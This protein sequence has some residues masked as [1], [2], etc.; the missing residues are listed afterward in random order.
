MGKHTAGPWGVGTMTET[1][2][3]GI[4]VEDGP[5]VA[6][7]TKWTSVATSDP[8]VI[9]ANASLIAAAPELLEALEAIMSSVDAKKVRLDVYELELAERAIAKANGDEPPPNKEIVRWVVNGLKRK[10]RY[11]S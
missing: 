9:Q 6:K 11:S 10:R 8:D 2:L 1:G 4:M 5:V 3:P 7:I